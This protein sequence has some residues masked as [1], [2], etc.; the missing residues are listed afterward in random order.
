MCKEVSVRSSALPRRA[1]RNGVKKLHGSKTMSKSLMYI[2]N[3]DA[4]SIPINDERPNF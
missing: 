2:G 1:V 4:S 3:K